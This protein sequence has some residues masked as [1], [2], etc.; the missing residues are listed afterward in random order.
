[1]L[2]NRYSLEDISL[3]VQPTF[4]ES[5]PPIAYTQ[6]CM[7]NSKQ[8]KPYGINQ[9]CQAQ[10]GDNI[11][12]TYITNN[13]VIRELRLAYRAVITYMD[14]ELGRV[15]DA[16][17][18]TG[19][20]NNTIV[21]FIGDHGYQNG[22]KGEWCKSDNFELATRIPMFV[23]APPSLGP[24]SRNVTSQVPVE[25]ID[26]FPTLVSLAGIEAKVAQQMAGESLEPLLRP[27]GARGVGG[28]SKVYA[29]SQWPRRP[30]CINHNSCTD[31]HGDPFQPDPDVAIMGYT[32]R[33]AEYRYGAWFNYNWDKTE[34]DFTKVLDRELY[35]HV[36]DTG[37]AQDAETYENVNLAGDPKHAAVVASMHKLMVAAVQE[38]LRPP[39]PS[40]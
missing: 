10:G 27:P 24:F 3:P 36:G 25:S 28:R 22:E 31:G 18:S 33:D 32:Y 26:L 6:N 38:S 37:N 30:S 9:T 34:P 8:V 7:A 12:R 20:A 13:T 35:T 11:C 15:L 23:S 29:L 14:K 19:L 2:Q 17:E 39:I 21:T 16:L 1:M 4:P 5:V 40:A